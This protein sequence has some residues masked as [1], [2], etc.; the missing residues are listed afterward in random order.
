M[1]HN[2]YSCTGNNMTTEWAHLP[3]AAHID[4]VLASA[5]ANPEHWALAWDT[6]WRAEQSAERT[7][8]SN[9]AWDAICSQGRVKAW[10]LVKQDTAG[11]ALRD[12]GHKVS[13][14]VASGALLA[15]VAYDECAYMLD[16]D[17]GELAIL[18]AFSDPRAVLLLSAC[19]AFHSLKTQSVT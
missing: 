1:R 11:L 16:S 17:P 14:Y 2:S 4:R 7:V 3:N 5:K 19:K 6:T 18:A 13:R 8:A 9:V 12:T 15:L 10:Y